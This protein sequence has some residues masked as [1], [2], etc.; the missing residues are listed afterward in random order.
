ML[1][2]VSEIVRHREDMS[3]RA[4]VIDREQDG[5]GWRFLKDKSVTLQFTVYYHALI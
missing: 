4:K 2:K 3:S 5:E 1:C